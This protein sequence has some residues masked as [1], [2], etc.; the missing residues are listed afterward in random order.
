MEINM[1]TWIV[2]AVSDDGNGHIK[3]KAFLITGESKGHAE[4]KANKILA[5]ISPRATLSLEVSLL[6]PKSV[7]DKQ[8][9]YD[10]KT[11]PLEN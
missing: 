6:G 9:T 3:H 5:L 1:K 10:G 7:I 8:F 2:S 4:I 11:Y